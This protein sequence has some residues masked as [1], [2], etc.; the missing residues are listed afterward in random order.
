VLYPDFEP[1]L[2][3][4]GKK[5]G[6]FRA[7]DV[8]VFQG[9]DDMQ[10]VR[11]G[12]GT[13]LFNKP[14]VFPAKFWLAFNIP[15]GTEIPASLRLRGP[16]YNAGFDADHYQ[17]EPGAKI[18]RLDSYKGALDSFARAAVVRSIALAKA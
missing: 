7:P 6:T 14:G 15:Q 18:M 16:H 17:I 10:Y 1:K 8:D 11:S 2:I 12:G 3:T 4:G 5:K 13:S 9:S